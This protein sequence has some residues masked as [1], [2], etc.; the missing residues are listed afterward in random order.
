MQL[1]LPLPRSLDA[2]ERRSPNGNQVNM[3]SIIRVNFMFEYVRDGF[4]IN[5]PTAFWAGL[6]FSFYAARLFLLGGLWD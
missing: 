4:P 3:V 1:S 6:G 5:P 2:W